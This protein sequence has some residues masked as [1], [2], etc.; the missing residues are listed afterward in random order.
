MALAREGVHGLLL[1]QKK[2]TG[3]RNLAQPV[4]RIEHPPPRMKD[5][6]KV[7]I[8]VRVKARVRVK[9]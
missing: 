6:G 1:R 7:M 4:N 9:R 2:N 3:K 5:Y 8:S